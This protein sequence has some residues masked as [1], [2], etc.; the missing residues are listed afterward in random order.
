MNSNGRGRRDGG[1][2]SA[3]S[4][5]KVVPL[6]PAGAGRGCLMV[7]GDA[8]SRRRDIARTIRKLRG[9]TEIFL[10]IPVDPLALGD[11]IAAVLLCW[12][13]QDRVSV[14]MQSQV[15]ASSLIVGG[16]FSH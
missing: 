12:L 7:D 14:S 10:V 9:Q 6:S 11:H 2:K 15:R 1:P 5:T 3:S 13:G 4:G 8:E 16:Y